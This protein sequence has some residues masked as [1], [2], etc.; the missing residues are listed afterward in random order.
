VSVIDVRSASCPRS[1]CAAGPRGLA[2]GLGGGSWDLAD[3][4]RAQPGRGQR[5]AHCRVRRVAAGDETSR[6]FTGSRPG[7][8]L[9]GDFRIRLAYRIEIR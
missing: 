4:L 6:P 9:D 7:R 5:D 8:D 2:A 1:F 3:L